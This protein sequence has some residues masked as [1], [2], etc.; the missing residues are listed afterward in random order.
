VNR[1]FVLR[2]PDGFPD[3]Q[4]RSFAAQCHVWRATVEAT[5]AHWDDLSMGR[6]G[7]PRP[8]YVFGEPELSPDRTLAILP[9]GGELAPAARS[10]LEPEVPDALHHDFPLWFR[11]ELEVARSDDGEDGPPR[12]Q[13]VMDPARAGALKES[14][15]FKKR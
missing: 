5:L 9:L 8:S 6:L 2:H 13:P 12:F 15:L 11:L 1:R 10:V 4:F 7:I 3:A 14:P